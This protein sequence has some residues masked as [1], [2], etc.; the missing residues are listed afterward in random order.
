MSESPPSPPLTTDLQLLAGDIRR[1]G[2]ELG[3]QAIGIAGIDPGEHASHFRD[4]L[5]K[6]F[7]GSMEWMANRAELRLSPAALLPGTVRVI[8]ARMDYLPANRD[9]LALL[10][11][12]EKAFISHYALGRDYH[13]LIRRRLTRLGEKIREAAGRHGFRAFV[14][15]A[16]VL[17][18]AYAEQA[19]L[20]WIGK[21]TLL[22][23]RNAGSW[24][25]LGEI[26]TDL[27]LP[28]D[29][30]VT[31]HCGRCEA[32]IDVC[33]TKAI[34][35]PWQLD[36]RRCISYLTIEHK[37][38]IPEEFRAAIGNRVFGCDDCQLVC[39]WNRFARATGEADFA[40]RHGLSD[41][42]LTTLFLW[43]EEEYL[44][45]TEGSPLRR[46]GWEQ[47]LRN[48]AVGLGNG[49]ASAEA[50][51]ALRQ[52]TEHPSSIVREHVVWALARLGALA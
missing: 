36:A 47:W 25:F 29:N 20:G 4:W 18:K 28:I 9:G 43:S 6:G 26:F 27:P 48:L 17:E 16:P 52:R 7:H 2:H 46:A 51:A 11:Q 13:K 42:L 44:Q 34:V 5:A 49:P 50:I 31:R 1:W 30:P 41:A 45:R 35:A 24:F 21:H 40:P 3:F 37:G 33:P 39:P 38:S 14:D 22:L 12:T 23:D 10:Q 19:G 15:S 32:C 8:V